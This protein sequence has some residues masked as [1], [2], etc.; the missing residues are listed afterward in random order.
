MLSDLVRHR[1]S[2]LA[3]RYKDFRRFLSAK[4]LLTLAL[5]MQFVVISWQVYEITQ[6][7]LSLGLLGLAEAV[8][9]V[10]VA[11]Y[12]GYVADRSD[13]RKVLVIL[14]FLQLVLA[15]LVWM[16]SGWIIS[17]RIQS[18]LPFYAAMFIV[19]AL[20]GFYS[21]SQFSLMTQLIPREAYANSSAWNSTFWHVGVVLGS[22]LGGLFLSWFG[23]QATYLIVAALVAAALIQISRIPAQKVQDVSR[24]EGVWQSIRQG[25][26]FV[27]DRQEILGALS[28]DLIAVLFGG[29]TAMLPAFAKDVL[30]VDETGFG[31]LRAAPFAGSVL[32]A[33]YMTRYP[34]LR[35]A[36]RKLLI[37]VS[38]FAGCMIAFAL[39]SDFYL[40]MAILALSGAFDN[41]SVVIRSTIIQYMTPEDMR[42]RV[43]A[44]STMFISSSNEIGAFESGFAAKLLGLIPS[45]VVGGGIALS[46]TFAAAAGLP[47]L[48][49]L[50]L[51]K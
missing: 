43:S 41:V 39:S 1:E 19:G 20:R 29:A 42:G 7:A 22:A 40:S 30:H 46:A 33:L 8:P 48:R 51:G 5:Q 17:G 23:K 31:L 4:F 45:V 15:F 9:A 49:K 27:F 28:L 44:V 47:K 11:L 6:D 10:S 24:S 32:M 25:L 38:G 2:F 16:A 36:G 14:T 37:C 3:F 21:P 35:N 50:Q 18:V 12:G 34:P 13:K 26:R